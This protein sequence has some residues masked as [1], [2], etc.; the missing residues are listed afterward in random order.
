M[1]FKQE[2][3]SCVKQQN[4]LLLNLYLNCFYIIQFITV[5]LIYCLIVY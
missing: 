5:F 3:S 1:V 2:S 4:I